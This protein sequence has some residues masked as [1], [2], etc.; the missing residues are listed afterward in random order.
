MPCQSRGFRALRTLSL[1][2]L[3]TAGSGAISSAGDCGQARFIKGADIS[4]LEE[5]EKGGGVFT[6][7]GEPR[8]ALDILKRH[9]FNFIRLRVWVSPAEGYCDLE[10]TLLMAERA[11]AKGFGLLI[12]LHYSDTWADPGRQTK[13]AAWSGVSGRALEDSVR[14]YT[15]GVIAALAAQGTLPDMVQ[16]GN[17]IVCGMLWDD[18]RVCDSFNTPERWNALARLIGAAVAGVRDATVPGDSVG[19]MI[20]IDRGGDNG[21]S[22]WFFDHLIAEGVDFDIIG[23]SFYPWWHHGTLAGLRDNLADLSERYGKGI[24][25]AETAYP[26]TL[27]WRDDEHNIVGL[28]EQLLPGY[29][30]TVG[31]QAAFLADLM[32]TVASAPASSGRG[33]FYWAPEWIAAPSFGSAWENVTL[34]DFSGEVLGSIGVFDSVYAGAGPPANP[35]TR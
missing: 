22:R 31:G 4:F 2:L 10:S 11:A 32:S 5:V 17:E 21:A 23:L 27:G 12:D 35:R 13:P 7:G 25:I 16:I 1:L 6:E 9:G 28:P 33:V 18:G 8:D 30:A 14:G 19:I 34:F 24:V 15:R 29:P 3:V 20:H 26:W